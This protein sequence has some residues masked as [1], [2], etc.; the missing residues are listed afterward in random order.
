MG[1]PGRG[2]VC[3]SLLGLHTCRIRKSTSFDALSLATGRAGRTGNGQRPQQAEQ[4][5]CRNWGTVWTG[6]AFAPIISGAA[7]SGSDSG[8]A[9]GRGLAI[10]P[11][12]SE[13]E[14]MLAHAFSWSS[15]T[16]SE[17]RRQRKVV[18]QRTSSTPRTDPPGTRGA[19]D[20]PVHIIHQPRQSSGVVSCSVCSAYLVPPAGTTARACPRASRS[21]L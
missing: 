18:S 1:A 15:A 7:V 20:A 4:A 6:A 3:P 12:P 10:I 14:L 17:R 2:R 13:H 8:R 16:S 11:C 21:T 5:V 9:H 19:A